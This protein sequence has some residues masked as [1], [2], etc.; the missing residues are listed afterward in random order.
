MPGVFSSQ[1]MISAVSFAQ[2]GELSC[3]PRQK[4][5]LRRALMFED[6]KRAVRITE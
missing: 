5:L 6:V 2:T 3:V 4:S 1:S